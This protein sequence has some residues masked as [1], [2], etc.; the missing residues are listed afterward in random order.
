MM[1][2]REE[3]SGE[4]AGRKQGLLAEWAHEATSLLEQLC[5]VRRERAELGLPEP[6]FKLHLCH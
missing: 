2:W 3:G 6:L 4:G 5:P 1:G